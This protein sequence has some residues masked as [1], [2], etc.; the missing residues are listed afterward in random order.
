[1]NGFFNSLKNLASGGAYAG[2]SASEYEELEGD[3]TD[4]TCKSVSISRMLIRVCPPPCVA[5][6]T[7]RNRGKPVNA[8]DVHARARDLCERVK[9][10]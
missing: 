6:G 1:M 10:S 9:C 8:G 4:Y 5:R 2:G 3:A 7:R